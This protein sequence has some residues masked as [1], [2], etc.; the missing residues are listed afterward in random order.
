MNNPKIKSIVLGRDN[1]FYLE[2]KQNLNIK[3]L[4]PTKKLME[5]RMEIFMGVVTLFFNYNRNPKSKYEK[6]Y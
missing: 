1:S 4:F 2:G 6:I 5:K 3:H